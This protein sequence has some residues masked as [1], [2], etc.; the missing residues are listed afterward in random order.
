MARQAREVRRFRAAGSPARRGSRI[1]DV[2]P[3]AH[4]AAA[5]LFHTDRLAPGIHTHRS[6]RERIVLGVRRSPD[7]RIRGRRCSQDLRRSDSTEP[8]SPAR[9]DCAA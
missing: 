5:G 7:A 8:G 3:G 6:S 9:T 1:P 2:E 4:S